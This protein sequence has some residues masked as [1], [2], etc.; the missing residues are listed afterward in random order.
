MSSTFNIPDE[1]ISIV[2]N[3][4]TR[5]VVEEEINEVLEQENA[6][7][8]LKKELI[9]E[10]SSSV[11]RKQGN[12]V[13]VLNVNS[14]NHNKDYN[15]SLLN[16]FKKLLTLRSAN[17]VL[18]CVNRDNMDNTGVLRDFI[19]E[20]NSVIFQFKGDF[21]K[22]K[23]ELEN[24]GV[25]LDLKKN[26]GFIHE[27]IL[28]DN[29]QLKDT[30]QRELTHPKSFLCF[31][32]KNQN[33][34]E[35][36]FFNHTRTLRP[37][38]IYSILRMSGFNKG[39]NGKLLD[40]T[41]ISPFCLEAMDYLIKTIGIDGVKELDELR[42]YSISFSDRIL[43]IIKKNFV[44]GKLDEYFSERTIFWSGNILD[45]LRETTEEFDI[46]IGQF[47]FLNK[48]FIIKLLPYLL[49]KSKTT[50]LIFDKSIDEE[51]F[52]H[53]FKG[54]MFVKGDMFVVSKTR[55]MQGGRSLFLIKMSYTNEKS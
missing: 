22:H 23:E 25:K 31:E 35:Y 30:S 21:K 34:R 33:N 27:L 11:F 24:L 50:I 1:F 7:S 53:I 15:N 17:K 20:F 42:F 36:R 14:K 9:A 52:K 28:K 54:A 39:F 55:I 32:V 16:I 46:V 41:S 29:S 51:E 8:E 49:E 37:S 3:E 47:L 48:N 43:N 19:K 44:V 6:L 5:R 26:N 2:I 12:E 38:I 13:L 4:G 40:L 10:E 18:Y 45:F